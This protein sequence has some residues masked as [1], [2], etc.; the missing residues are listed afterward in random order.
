MPFGLTFE[1]PWVLLALLAL[2]LLP[3]SRAWGLRVAALA[4][5]VV[6]L[7]QPGLGRP[8]RDVAL[9]VDV[10][11]SL[12]VKGVAAAR[13]LDLSGLKTNPAVFYFG[14]DATSV[15]ALNAD[16]PE[17]LNTQQTDLA[18]A[19]QVAQASGAS[20]ALLISDGAESVG[21]AL[22]ALPG[23]AVDTL[24][25]NSL[26]NVR[27]VGLLA[28]EQVSPFETVEVTAVVESDRPGAIT[29][30][31]TAAG[32][33][34]EPVTV[35]VQ[36]GRQAVSFTVQAGNTDTL[37]V[38][39]ALQTDFEQPTSDDSGE[40]AIN[41]SEGS[42]VLVIDDSALAE[43]LQAQGIEVTVGTPADITAPLAF[44]AVALRGSAGNFTTG[45]L[46]LLKTYV[47]DGGGLL[48]TGGPESFGFG[49]WYRTPV[50]EVLPVNTD[51]RTEVELPL[52]AL[53]IVLDRSQSMAT[54]NPS[55]IELA[56]EG[57][58][59]V[60][61]LA[62][63]DDL[64]GLIVFSDA[65]ATE[66]AFDLRRATER[67][68]R[69]MAAAI[70]GIQ[71]QGGTILEPAYKQAIDALASTEA[72][73]KHII[74]LSDGK[75]YDGGVFG[76]PS[77]PVDFNSTAAAAGALGITTSAIAI[78]EGADF[79]RMESI[80]RSG[81]GRYYAA[82]DVNTLPRIFTNEALTATRS[83][84]REDSLAPTLRANPLVPEG[85]GAPP[86]L[87]AYIATTLKPTA[88]TILEGLQ[89]EP[90]LAVSRQ[91][92][93]RSAAFTTDLNAWAGS[94]GEWEALPGLLG[95]VTRW[96]QTRPADFEATVTREGTQF[97]VVVDAVRGGDY[98]NGLPL[99]ARYGGTTTPLAQ[100]AP[101]RY[102]GLVPAAEGG[103]L[104]VLDGDEIVARENVAAPDA[105]FD[106]AG[107]ETLLRTVAERTGGE[108]YTSLDRYAPSTP[109]DA[110]PLWP[111][112]ALAGLIVF[113]LEL[114]L[115]RFGPA[116]RVGTPV[117]GD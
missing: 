102:E 8:S 100:V 27:L 113:L 29:L 60:V 61:D 25:L 81:G 19:L 37:Q 115:R 96:L 58:L 111:W 107:G 95:T 54:G 87:D 1:A 3:R 89:G 45:Q 51:L 10:S 106:T 63:Q 5:L 88:E 117:A 71:T 70:L 65:N 42:S 82:L 101:G 49:A 39:A 64:L 36:Q 9:L 85:L 14:T 21:D 108:F 93:G 92:L 69:E 30:W 75:L 112:V 11:D 94:L 47:Q 4:L 7:A 105:E 114:V 57:A 34:L 43:L 84:L 32:E 40:V 52:V 68:K 33:D 44:D 6:A 90:V 55:K 74:I 79:E 104:L 77:Q 24:H 98:V 48:M 53:V 41:V 20:R 22:L 91:G 18:R 80:A 110:T 86:A 26:D 66:W 99:E 35:N 17:F 67:G 23:F 59:G 12:G 16:V 62:Y 116:E 97:K 28:P 31:P 72:A 38:A 103:T 78:G 83:L 46:E 2:P 73:I 56:K 109:D 76:A 50:E 13:S 15:T